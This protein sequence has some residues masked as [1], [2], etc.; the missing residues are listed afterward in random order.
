M[1]IEMHQCTYIL[2][3]VPMQVNVCTEYFS[4]DTKV[5]DLNQNLW[6]FISVLHRGI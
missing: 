2:V 5:E 6:P 3:S 1:N 4:G